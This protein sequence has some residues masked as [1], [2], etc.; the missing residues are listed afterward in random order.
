MLLSIVTYGFNIEMT[1]RK[2]KSDMTAEQRHCIVHD[3]KKMSESIFKTKIIAS[4]S[5]AWDA[6]PT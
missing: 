4:M 3:V 5:N 6:R 1:I 2:R